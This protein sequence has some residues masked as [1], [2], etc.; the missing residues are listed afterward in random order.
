MLPSS[1]RAAHSPPRAHL[2]WVLDPSPCALDPC[3]EQNPKSLFIP[4]LEPL[5][6]FFSQLAQH[7]PLKHASSEEIEARQ[8]WM[9]LMMAIIGLDSCKSDFR[10]ASGEQC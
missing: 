3:V 2:F 7:S 10:M 4:N 1:L 9:L 6:Y 5:P 8:A